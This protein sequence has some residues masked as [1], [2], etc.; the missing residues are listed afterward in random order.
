MVHSVSNSLPRRC[1]AKNILEEKGIT[2]I[3]LILGMIFKGIFREIG[4]NSEKH[5]IKQGIW[6]N[7]ARFKNERE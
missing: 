6:G 5:N 1:K 3:F 2:K 4:R 7:Y